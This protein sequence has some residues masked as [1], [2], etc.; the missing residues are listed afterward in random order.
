MS[1]T[2]R[3]QGCGAQFNSTAAFDKHRTGN[4][5]TVREPGD[6]RC[7]TESEMLSKGMAVN[8]RGR[9]VTALRTDYPQSTSGAPAVH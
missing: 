6:R 8:G 1:D 4:Y 9:W 2:C 5:G 3:C 7:L